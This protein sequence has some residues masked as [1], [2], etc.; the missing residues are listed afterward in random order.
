MYL[1]V[2]SAKLRWPSDVL[3]YTDGSWVAYERRQENE[4]GAFT[5]IFF[6]FI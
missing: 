2:L 6:F 1:N 5:L 4:D 3:I